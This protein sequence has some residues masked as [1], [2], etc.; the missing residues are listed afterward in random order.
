VHT[1]LRDFWLYQKEVIVE[2]QIRDCAS[3]LL[4]RAI[5]A[6]E[7]TARHA[8]FSTSTGGSKDPMACCTHLDSSQGELFKQAE[9]RKPWTEGS[10]TAAQSCLE[11][12]IAL[13]EV[14]L[15]L[16]DEPVAQA[17]AS[18]HQSHWN[19]LAADAKTAG[20]AAYRAALVL[21]DPSAVD[22]G[23][24]AAIAEQAA[25]PLKASCSSFKGLACQ[26]VVPQV[27]LGEPSGRID[28]QAHHRVLM[29]HPNVGKF[30]DCPRELGGTRSGS[31]L[32]HCTRSSRNAG[33][34]RTGNRAD[35]QQSK[36]ERPCLCPR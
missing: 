18:Q 5:A 34:V 13:L 24:D 1:V 3:E 8:C 16:I 2:K 6:I 9:L 21:L 35:E 19:K 17:T 31:P 7:V 20:R 25:A 22:R 12:S 26:I 32:D 29:T 23:S 11:S 27:S 4:T 30:V 36:K 28:D 33:T 14:V 10:I 15:S